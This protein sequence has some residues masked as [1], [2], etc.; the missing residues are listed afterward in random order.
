[1]F[2]QSEVH[3]RLI[4]VGDIDD[5]SLDR[6][7]LTLSEEELARAYL[8]R[9][10]QLR[11]EFIASH[12]ALRQML[13]EYLHEDPVAIVFEGARHEKPRV[14]YPAGT[15]IEFSLS[16]SGGKV[17]YAFAAGRRV[18]ADIE[19]VNP[20]KFD[21]TLPANIFSETELREWQSLPDEIKL[22]GFFSG[23]TRKE[24]FIKALGEGL[25]LDLKS[26]SVTIDASRPA[27]LK[28]PPDHAH[29]HWNLHPLAPCAG[30]EAAV[31]VEGSG[32][33]IV[34]DLAAS[35]DSPAANSK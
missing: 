34:A 24:A 11:S 16:H 21:P 32:Y 28:P 15:R 10:E 35:K 9:T 14:V 2:P 6:Y 22:R 7:A 26:F 12:G 31:V 8:L 20:T 27:E 30:F 17:L 19:E 25:S 1:M 33:E 18:G 3:I 23:W 29:Q 13:A 4:S 5:A